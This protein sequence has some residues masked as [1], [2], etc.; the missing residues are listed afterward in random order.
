M[1][2]QKK[3]NGQAM[4]REPKPIISIKEARKFLGEAYDEFTDDE[5]MGIIYTM[6][7]VVITQLDQLEV[8]ESD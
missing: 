7:R 4:S 5:I 6:T 8:P 1:V 2:K 3:W